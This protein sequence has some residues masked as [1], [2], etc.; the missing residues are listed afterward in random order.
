MLSGSGVLLYDRIAGTSF[1]RDFLPWLSFM[2]ERFIS[3]DSAGRIT[4]LIG[5]FDDEINDGLTDP[6]RQSGTN[7]AVTAWS[8]LPTA[9]G[10]FQQMYEGS[11]KLFLRDQGDGTAYMS[12]ANY[13]D[14]PA[15]TA[16]GLTAALAAEL[17]DAVT[18]TK[19]RAYIDAHYQP[20]WDNAR[21]EFYYRFGLNE[22]WPRGQ[23]NAWVMPAEL[24]H[25]AG[26]WS[27]IFQ[28]P[29]LRKFQAPTLEGVEFPALRVRQAHYDERARVLRVAVTCRDAT[30]TGQPTVVQIA[31]L[32][33]QSPVRVSVDGAPATSHQATRGRLPI[34]LRMGA[35]S[36]EVQLG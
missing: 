19:L 23:M 20:T 21:G 6:A 15:E 12:K 32:P 31:N 10:F 16:T 24:L 22:A 27:G 2:R 34:A 1:A 29:N 9:P 18:Q 25:T 33:R 3:R 11:L 35:H 36:I 28:K 30:R 26:Q 8:G 17:G 7:W 4:N 13:T 14:A 5:Y